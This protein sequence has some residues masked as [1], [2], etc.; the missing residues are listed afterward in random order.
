MSQRT[1]DPASCF[2]GPIRFCRGQGCPAVLGAE[3]H[4]MSVSF[5]RTTRKPFPSWLARTVQDSAPAWPMPPRRAPSPKE[6]AGLLIAVRGA[7]GE[8]KMDAVLDRLGVGDRHEAHAGG[9]V[10]AGPDDDLVLPPGQDLSS[11]APASRTGPC[12][13]DRVRQPRCDAVGRA[14]LEYGRHAG[15]YPGNPLSCRGRVVNPAS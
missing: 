8:V 10:L 9:R 6:A 4:R 11:R 7:A 12:R 5:G 2:I 1:P 14:C 13:A 3:P 15:P